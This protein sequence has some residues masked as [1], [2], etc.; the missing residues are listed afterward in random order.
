ML[1]PGTEMSQVLPGGGCR[2]SPGL[3]DQYK[4]KRDPETLAGRQGLTPGPV[5]LQGMCGRSALESREGG[6]VT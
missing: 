4:P 6:W 1:I 3:Q 5:G 2:R